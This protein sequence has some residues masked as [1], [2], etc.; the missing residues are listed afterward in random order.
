MSYRIYYLKSWT[1]DVKD[2]KNSGKTVLKSFEEALNK[3]VANPEIGD[4]K[5]GDLQ[6]VFTY[7]FYGSHYRIAYRIF[8]HCSTQDICAKLDHVGECHG[9]IFFLK[10]GHRKNFYSNKESF[11]VMIERE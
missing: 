11:N 4:P 6:G 7:K 8:A 3:I 1:R 2:I 10:C 5:K 9:L